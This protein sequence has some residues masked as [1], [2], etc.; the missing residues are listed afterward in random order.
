MI[1]SALFEQLVAQAAADDVEQLVVGGIVR[2]DDTVL[3]LRRPADDF[4]GG[5]FE[6][7]SGKVEPGEGLDDALIREVKEETGLDVTAI[8]DYLD[9]FDYASGSGRK[10]RQFTFAVDVG[11][12]KPVVLQEHDVYQWAQL[13][14]ELPVTDA[15]K[16]VLKECVDR[17]HGD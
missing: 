4:M 16:A 9:Y 8:V 11:A 6:L 1:D 5:I 17:N 14:G 2:H 3:L 12:T 7:P 10:S 15:V 13:D